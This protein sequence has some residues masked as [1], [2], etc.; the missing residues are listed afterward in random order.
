MR[1]M[2]LAG[3]A[4]L[5]AVWVGCGEDGEVATE[6]ND[7]CFAHCVAQEEQCGGPPP[8]GSCLTYCDSME[9]DAVFKDCEDSWTAWMQCLRDASDPCSPECESE[10]GAFYDCG[11]A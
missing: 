5:G 2:G 6:G 8:G 4:L 10:G 7:A 3:L 1:W 9:S 11:P